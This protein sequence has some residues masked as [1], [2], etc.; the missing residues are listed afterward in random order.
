MQARGAGQT[1]LEDQKSEGGKIKGPASDRKE[2]RS[3]S[4][5]TV[6]GRKTLGESQWKI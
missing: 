5:G 6:G 1:L 4:G 2:H 3:G